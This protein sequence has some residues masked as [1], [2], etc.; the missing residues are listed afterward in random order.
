MSLRLAIFASLVGMAFSASTTS[1]APFSTEVLVSSSTPAPMPTLI[2]STVALGSWDKGC[3]PSAGGFFSGFIPVDEDESNLATFRVTVRTTNPLV[4]YCTAGRH[5]QDGMYG[6]VNPANKSEAGGHSL[7]S[8]SA[9]AKNASS[10]IS[11]PAVMGGT[12]A[13]NGTT[14]NETT[15]G[16][17]CGGN[18]AN[19]TSAST[20]CIPY[21][22]NIS[23]SAV[24]LE[25]S[26]WAVMAAAMVGA[27]SLV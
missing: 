11:P 7:T 6:I 27:V 21:I 15:N 12:L 19:I 1:I 9:M 8:Y 20:W 22:P 5:C 10:N 4:F 16:T 14:I 24:A 3:A 23:S 18:S 26:I 25:Q 13:F 17:V 2:T